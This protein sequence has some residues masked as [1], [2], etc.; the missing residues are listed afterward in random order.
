MALGYPA[1]SA[2]FRDGASFVSHRSVSSLLLDEPDVR[3]S[4]IV[5]QRRRDDPKTDAGAV[6]A[7][8]GTGTE[9][10]GRD[11]GR[12][13][14]EVPTGR[15][16]RPRG[17][18]RAARSPVLSSTGSRCIGPWSASRDR[19]SKP[20]AAWRWSKAAAGRDEP[21]GH[22]GR[23]DLRR[24]GRRGRRTARHEREPVPSRSFCRWP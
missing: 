6:A 17:R 24:D 13:G 9:R 19:S 12:R 7:P 15:S 23:A 18:H 14:S 2:R 5:E 1:S 4:R 21:A 16:G 8:S 22:R 20:R 11:G 3:I 10:Y